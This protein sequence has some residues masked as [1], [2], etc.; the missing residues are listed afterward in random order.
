MNGRRFQLLQEAA[1]ML[2]LVRPLLAAPEQ[3]REHGP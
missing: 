2:D 1:P 3:T